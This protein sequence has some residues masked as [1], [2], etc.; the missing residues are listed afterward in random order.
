MNEIILI[1]IFVASILILLGGGVW[2]GI[3]LVA[4]S[5]I[6]MELFYQ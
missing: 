3:S 5:I 4:A 2:V 1:S 6:G